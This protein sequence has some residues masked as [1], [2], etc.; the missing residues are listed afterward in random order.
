MIGSPYLH[1][2]DVVKYMNHLNLAGVLFREVYFTPTFSKHQNVLCKGVEVVVTNEEAFS[3][4]KTGY[5]LL[6]YILV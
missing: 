3:P 1:N 6:D 2:R 5:L 4:V